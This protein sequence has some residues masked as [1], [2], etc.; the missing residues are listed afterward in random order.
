MKFL[1]FLK[2]ISFI[3]HLCTVKGEIAN[4]SIQ[5]ANQ[6]IEDKENYKKRGES[7]IN[8]LSSL[9]AAVS[10]DRQSLETTAQ[11]SVASFSSKPHNEQISILNYIKRTKSSMDEN[12]KK[13]GVLYDKYS[14]WNKAMD[15]VFVIKKSH[16]SSQKLRE[17]SELSEIPT[18]QLKPVISYGKEMSN[19]SHDEAEF[20]YLAFSKYGVDC[21][22]SL[23]TV[24]NRIKEAHKK[25]ADNAVLEESY[26]KTSRMKRFVVSGAWLA[27]FLFVFLC[28]LVFGAAEASIL[29]IG[30]IGAVVLFFV[31]L[32]I[33][34]LLGFATVPITNFVMGKIIPKAEKRY[35]MAL[36]DIVSSEIEFYDEMLQNMLSL[37]NTNNNIITRN[38]QTLNSYTYSFFPKKLPF[39]F[40]LYVRE[41]ML[42]GCNFSE[43]CWRAEQTMSQEQWKAEMRKKQAA[44]DAAEKKWRE[45]V[46]ESQKR[47]EAYSREEAEA[48][49]AQAYQLEQRNQAIREASADYRA[50]KAELQKLRRGY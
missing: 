35:G 32:L 15:Y 23:N 36:S 31:M 41:Q 17:L 13:A 21:Y 29:L 2:K 11:H 12:E 38:Q 28:N 50:C 10:A 1:N 27:F 30:T 40:V 46:L 4:N 7:I 18:E 19:L 24:N 20:L 44:N 8:E 16:I 47:A 43:A 49:R 39:S 25:Y 5:I 9:K 34:K 33:D 42:T 14:G 37:I 26:I 48:A 22:Y 45:Q 3:A 6:L